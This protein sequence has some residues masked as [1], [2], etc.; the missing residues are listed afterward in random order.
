MGEANRR[1]EAISGTECICGSG[2]AAGVCCFINGYWHKQAATLDLRRSGNS[3]ALES[4][5]LA[6]LGAC[7][8][9]ISGEHLISESVMRLLAGDGQF[10][11]GGTPWLSKGEFRSVG[12]KSLTAKCLCHDHNSALHHLDDAALA[13]FSS[14]RSAFEA[15]SKSAK[16]IIS[17]HDLERWLLKTLKAMA[18]S[19]N[20]GRGNERLSGEFSNGVDVAAL[21]ENIGAWKPGLGLYCIMVA[22]EKTQNH[23]R[24]QLAPL[25]SDSGTLSGLWANIL[26]VSF[27]LM[28]EPLDLAR[29]PQAWGSVHRPAAI[30]VDHPNVQNMVHISWDDGKRH[31]SAL[32][33]KFLSV[34]DEPR[35]LSSD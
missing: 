6:E 27:I 20:L 16:S 4:C 14:L 31:K 30:I 24:F 10:T 8:G 3:S 12:F 17:G 22:G 15:D 5:Y 23:N 34:V 25:T 33:L 11:I 18:V 28:L 7:G 29:S 1:R 21:L 13:F 19:K 26:G 32:T 9:S 2:K 35:K